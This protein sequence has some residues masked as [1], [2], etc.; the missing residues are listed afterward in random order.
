MNILRI[1]TGR[2][3]FATAA[4]RRRRKTTLMTSLTANSS[5]V[6]PSF[7]F[8]SC[9]SSFEQSLSWTP[10]KRCVTVLLHPLKYF[11]VRV[12]LIFEFDVQ[13]D[14]YFS[15]ELLSGSCRLMDIA[16]I[17]TW[18]RVIISN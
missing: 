14:F 17:Y 8:G 9:A 18:K 2:H 7:R 12:N 4:Q 1:N 10:N 3:R 16:Y 15:D 11:T 6:L 5:S 13:V